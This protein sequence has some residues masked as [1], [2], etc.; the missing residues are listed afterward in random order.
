MAFEQRNNSGSLFKNDRKQQD[1]H[2]DY[3]GS[4]MIDGVEYWFDAWIK[5]AQTGKN[6][7]Q[8]YM[9]ASFK[10]KEQQEPSRRQQPEQQQ[11]GP[12][13]NPTPRKGPLP[14]DGDDSSIPF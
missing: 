3:K 4:A 5:T 2:P 7:G 13:N 8:K 1:N 14:D 9:S 6:A 10:P 11:R 12:S